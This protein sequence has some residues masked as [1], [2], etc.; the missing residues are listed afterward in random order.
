MPSSPGVGPRQVLCHDDVLSEKFNGLE[1][2]FPIGFD[3]AVEHDFS[4]AIKDAEVHFLG[5]KVDSAIILVLFG[6]KPHVASF[7]GLRCFL[8]QEAFYHASGGGLQ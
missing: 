8:L 3:V 1:E 2:D 7:F 4:G 6:V 5:M